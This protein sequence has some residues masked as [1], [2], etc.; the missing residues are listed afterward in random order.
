MGTVLI[1]SF[2]IGKALTKAGQRSM[3][4]S[5]KSAAYRRPSTPRSKGSSSIGS[6]LVLAIALFL[7][8]ILM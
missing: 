5:T 6:W 8:L 3:A 1:N 7:F 2:N 4:R